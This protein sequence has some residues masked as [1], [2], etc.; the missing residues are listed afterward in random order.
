MADDH[1]VRAEEYEQQ[2]V[3]N[4]P[5]HR[6]SLTP[7]A[8]NEMGEN[9]HSRIVTMVSQISSVESG[10]NYQEEEGFSRAE[11]EERPKQILFAMIKSNEIENL[12]NH[13]AETKDLFDIM[14]IS[15]DMG[16]SP[17]HFAAYKSQLQTCEILIDFIL[18]V[19]EPLANP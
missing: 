15:N 7:M 10:D 19:Q 13:L 14:Q 8:A 12:G 3:T 4:V 1:Y 2:T 5:S 18:N 11:A 17:I 16:F 9:P 6:R